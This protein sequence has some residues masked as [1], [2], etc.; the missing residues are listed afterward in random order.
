MNKKNTSSESKNSEKTEP[1]KICNLMA[2]KELK[3]LV[4]KDDDQ[5]EKTTTMSVEPENEDNEKSKTNS[6]FSENML[7]TTGTSLISSLK[8]TTKRRRSIKSQSTIGSTKH[9][10][11]ECGKIFSR[12]DQYERHLLVHSGQKRFSC[13]NCPKRFGQRSELQKHE[14]D[15][16]G[17]ISSGSSNTLAH[18]SSDETSSDQAVKVE[19][20]DDSE[21]IYCND[22]KMKFENL[23]DLQNHSII[24][25]VGPL[26]CGHCQTKCD[27]LLQHFEL[28]IEL[29]SNFSIDIKLTECDLCGLYFAS[30]TFCAKHKLKCPKSSNPE[31]V[32]PEDLLDEFT[33]DIYKRSIRKNKLWPPMKTHIEPKLNIVLE[34]KP[35][36]MSS[37]MDNFPLKGFDKTT[38]NLADES[39]CSTATAD[40]D[41]YPSPQKMKFKPQNSTVSELDQIGPIDN[42]FLSKLA[43]NPTLMKAVNLLDNEQKAQQQLNSSLTSDINCSPNIQITK[44]PPDDYSLLMKLFSENNPE[45]ESPPLSHAMNI[46]SSASM[47]SNFQQPSTFQDT[48]IIQN[49][50]IVQNNAVSQ[51]MLMQNNPILQNNAVIGGHPMMQN[52]TILENTPILQNTSIVQN[53]SS[54][55]PINEVLQSPQRSEQLAQLSDSILPNNQTYQSNSLSIQS[56]QLLHQEQQTSLLQQQLVSSQQCSP[57][58]TYLTEPSAYSELSPIQS[59]SVQKIQQQ[60]IST[61][62]YQQQHI[63][64]T[65]TVVQN[66]TAKHKTSRLTDLLLNNKPEHRTPSTDCDTRLP[67]LRAEL[68]RPYDRGSS[69]PHAV[70]KD[71]TN[72]CVSDMSKVVATK[73]DNQLDSFFRQGLLASTVTDQKKTVF[74]ST[75]RQ[76]FPSTEKISGQLI[77][78]SHQ[79]N[80][81]P[82]SL[83]RSVIEQTQNY[84]P[85]IGKP[86]SSLEQ[87]SQPTYS[88][89]L[90]GSN[91]SFY[92]KSQSVTQPNSLGQLKISP[93]K[94][95]EPV[96][97]TSPV[98]PL[99]QTEFLCRLCNISYT[100][101]SHYA[102]H[103]VT[104]HAHIVQSANTNK[105][106]EKNINTLTTTITT[107]I[108]TTASDK[109][110]VLK[111]ELP[112]I[113]VK[114]G[115]NLDIKEERM[116]EKKSHLKMM[117]AEKK[118]SCEICGKKYLFSCN[119]KKHIAEHNSKV[120]ISNESAK[121]SE[122]VI[123]SPS[124]LFL[125]S[126]DIKAHTSTANESSTEVLSQ[127]ARDVSDLPSVLD[128]LLNNNNNNKIADR[129]QTFKPV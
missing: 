116:F 41:S 39:D 119:L 23:L 28:C 82:D 72:T 101:M 83:Q 1:T 4:V 12:V 103:I 30:E 123:K 68:D 93:Q 125:E 120:K 47:H 122:V 54:V 62:N 98:S 106:I 75:Q 15:I 61:T 24:C 80:F 84:V 118:F 48:S 89:M 104:K 3:N 55:L 65:P 56:T 50:S 60:N 63:L 6:L 115:D 124:V 38:L 42:N 32:I 31:K 87:S 110:T 114:P 13:R 37:F 16:H 126:Q 26:I 107:T 86:S 102:A 77:Q 58:Q 128:N 108:Q 94:Q 34:Q 99:N 7:V 79:Q 53:V 40:T 5:K 109:N 22:C 25:K 14:K 2:E 73:L 11:S 43:N 21:T 66:T 69:L 45:L 51:H 64:L 76:S 27:N 19:N 71:K 97:K 74:Q 88:N 70:N 95:A 57:V 8:R 96:L 91:N 9:N 129:Q 127:K 49:N 17:I 112:N 113:D 35:T 100:N 44:P 105:D 10:C 29:K 121:S 46:Q 33:G 111:S 117:N 59:T 36:A 18:T 92:S 90:P 78:T 85:F 67:L 81:P 20:M 52:T